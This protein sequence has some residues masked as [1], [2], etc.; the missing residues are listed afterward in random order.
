MLHDIAQANLPF[1]VGEKNKPIK[2]QAANELGESECFSRH[3]KTQTW[4]VSMLQMDREVLLLICLLKEVK[5]LK[6]EVQQLGAP[7]GRISL[8]CRRIFLI[9]SL[10]SEVKGG[11]RKFSLQQEIRGGMREVA[12]RRGFVGGIRETYRK[13]LQPHVKSS[14]SPHLQ[15]SSSFWKPT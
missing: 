8:E 11:K 13:S 12:R 9:F 6:E 1:D 4:F 7:K 2:E 10:A 5:W 15:R 14:S 3:K